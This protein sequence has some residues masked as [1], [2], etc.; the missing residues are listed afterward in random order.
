MSVAHECI[1]GG[2][3]RPAFDEE[4]RLSALRRYA[5]LDSAPEAAFDDLA[6]VVAHACDAPVAVINF[7]DRE[8]QW[9]KA[10]RGFEVRETALDL[11]ICRLGLLEDGLFVIPD[12]TLDPRCA[13]NPLVRG[14]PHLRFYAGAVLISPEGLPL[15]TICVLDYEPRPEGLTSAQAEILSA[16]AR[17]TMREL[18][19]RVERGFFEVALGTM[20]QGLLMIEPDGRVPIVNARAVELL[21]LPQDF[22][23]SR[24]MFRELVSYQTLQGEFGEE[25]H[26]RQRVTERRMAEG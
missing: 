11:S 9:F 19:L 6:M 23:D 15:G 16:M 12:T 21:D 4:K 8:R 3:P 10:R 20:D 22:V 18:E 2:S 7:I 5:I 26:D 25:S 1:G 24:P 14:E 17:A 13:D